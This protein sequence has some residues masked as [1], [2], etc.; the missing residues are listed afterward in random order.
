MPNRNL[1]LLISAARLLTPLLDELVFV[2][3]CVTGLLISDPAAADVRPTYDVD[4]LAE[5]GSY[6]EYA[7]LSVRLRKL[8]F[9]EDYREGAPICRWLNGKLVLDVMPTD[10]KILGFSNRWYKASMENA[11]RINLEKDLIIRV[12]TAPYFFAMKLEAFRGRG[13]NDYVASHDFEDLMAVIDGRPSLLTELRASSEDL[14]IY[15]S[16]E[17]ENLL[18]KPAFVDALPGYLLPDATNQERVGKLLKTLQ[19]ISKVVDAK[20]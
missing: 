19:E 5:I 9:A 7:A 4:A 17:I 1:P 8:G 13:K 2:G 12:A 6:A 20:T 11:N 3:G 18:R 16:S 15:V 14:K 10:E